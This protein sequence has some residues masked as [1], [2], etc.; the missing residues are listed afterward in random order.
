MVSSKRNV[1]NRRDS[2]LAQCPRAP[3]RPCE[4]FLEALGRP[5]GLKKHTAWKML[6]SRLMRLNPIEYYTSPTGSSSDVLVLQDSSIGLPDLL[7]D[8][9]G[10]SAPKR[11]KESSL[12]HFR[13][14]IFQ[15]G[16]VQKVPTLSATCAFSTLG[17][18][19][20]EYKG[21]QIVIPSQNSSSRSVCV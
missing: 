8:P 5:R 9:K 21:Q 2:F 10:R 12:E 3:C 19:A 7:D 13:R 20:Q 18:R 4:S 11:L 6:T 15:F 1:V 14:A 17:R 16:A